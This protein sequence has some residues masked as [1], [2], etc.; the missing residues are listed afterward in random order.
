MRHKTQKS[1]HSPAGAEDAKI[2]RGYWLEAAREAFIDGGVE[3]VKVD[4][5]ARHLGVTRGGFYWAFANR[6]DLL[7]ALLADWVESNSKAL[8]DAATS[9]EPGDGARK[10]VAISRV[11]I[12]EK[13]F[14][15]AHD[16]AVRDWARIS[17]A[18]AKVVRKVDAE[19]VS[20]LQRIFEE[21]GF[22]GEDAET[23]A[24]IMYYHQV[25]YYAMGVRQGR[26]ARLRS[27]PSYFKAL[28]GLDL[29]LE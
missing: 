8:V 29:R 4:R 15:P 16:A 1:D 27:I 11:W 6:E 12:E 9:G 22:E 20:L 10:F 13:G 2:G 3:N 28:T 26:A 19:R 17:K 14:S 7:K 23:R 18:V 21:L 5:L 25:G 24:R